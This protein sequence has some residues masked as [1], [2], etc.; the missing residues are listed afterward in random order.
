MALV[1]MDTETGQILQ[2]LLE[3]DRIVRKKSIEA[4]L[5][6]ERC[7]KGETFSKVYHKVIPL[8]VDCN[9]TAAELVVFIYLTANLR[10]LSNVAKYR[11]GKLITRDNLH[12]YLKL[13]M[14][15]V[16]RS[17]YRLIKEGLIIEANTIEGKVFVVN[18]FVVT[19]GDKVNKTIYDLFRKSRWARW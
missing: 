2:E 12:E 6:F 4:H 10:Y 18:P 15:T 16:K 9:L 7:P 14:P 3:G 13:S 19:V 17:V 11:N 5:E 1:L 8:L